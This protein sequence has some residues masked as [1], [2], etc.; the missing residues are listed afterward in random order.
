[1]E[2]AQKLQRDEIETIKLKPEQTKEILNKRPATRINPSAQRGYDPEIYPAITLK[3]NKKGYERNREYELDLLKNYILKNGQ[4][5]KSRE[6]ILR[7]FRKFSDIVKGHKNEGLFVPTTDLKADLYYID[8]RSDLIKLPVDF[9]ANSE[10]ADVHMVYFNDWNINNYIYDAE[11]IDFFKQGNI[12]IITNQ[13]E[14][15]VAIIKNL[16]NSEITQ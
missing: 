5:I 6:D 2:D 13:D 11:V 1:M 4:K 7:Y 3:E 10:F 16:I 9:D 12:K 15:I 14:P 8:N